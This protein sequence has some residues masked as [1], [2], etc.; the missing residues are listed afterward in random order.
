MALPI[1]LQIYSVRDELAKDFYGTLKKVKEMGYDGVELA[2]LDGRD[3]VEVKKMLEELGLQMISSHVPVAEMLEEGGIERYK[4]A[5][6]KYIAIPWMA[7]G[8]NNEEL[9]D[10]LKLIRK[11]ADAVKAQGM[12]LLYHNHDFEFKTVDGKAA[13]DII[14]DT[15]PAEL[16]QTELD[17]CWVKFAGADPISYLKKYAGRAPLVHLKDFFK[18]EGDNA[19][20]YELIGTDTSEKQ[21]STFEFRPVGYGIQDMPAILAAS[22]AAGADW[23]VVE[24]D[25]SV[26]R[27]TLEAAKLSIDYLHSLEW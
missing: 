20:P 6:C 18:E 3:P 17:T 15:V 22:K 23:V 25:E 27:S 7:H 2:G 9:E 21:K 8:A 19:V 24:Q 13:L 16:L 26:G 14:Y 12:T 10:N 1:A 5:G 11:L 4:A